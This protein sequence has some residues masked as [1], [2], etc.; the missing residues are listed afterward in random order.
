M[1]LGVKQADTGMIDGFHTQSF[2][3]IVVPSS[4]EKVT[5]K[6]EIVDIENQD[7]VNL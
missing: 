3:L 4:S 2:T 7:I 1:V 6:A 5:I